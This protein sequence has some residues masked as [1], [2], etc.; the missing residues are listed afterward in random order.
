MEYL[1]TGIALKKLEAQINRALIAYGREPLQE[2]EEPNVVDTYKGIS[3]G[4]VVTI[5][6]GR[7]GIVEH[8]MTGGILGIA[9]SPFAIETSEENPG[10][11]IRLIR[12]GEQTEFLLN[13]KFTDVVN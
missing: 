7:S 11:T 9:G 8:I 4:D 12:D 5:R 13:I 2:A 6:D 1:E 3:N 10:M